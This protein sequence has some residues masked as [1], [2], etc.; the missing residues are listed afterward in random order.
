MSWNLPGPFY[1]SLEI[2]GG[3]GS[4]EAR[5]LELAVNL[6]STLLPLLLEQCYC[7][8]VYRDSALRSLPGEVAAW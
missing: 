8:H 5:V 2:L 1:I 7:V 4:L 6:G 3:R